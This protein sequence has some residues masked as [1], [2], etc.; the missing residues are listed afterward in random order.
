[1]RV[2][3]PCSFVVLETLGG[4]LI[5]RAVDGI[6][7]AL[8]PGDF[9]CLLVAIDDDAGAIQTGV[10]A[11]ERGDDA[12]AA[13]FDRPEIYEQHLI[14]AVMNQFAESVTA[15]RQ[16]RCRKFAFE[17]RILHAIP[18]AAHAL[19]DAA[20]AEVVGNVVADE[21]S[22]PH[23]CAGLS[24]RAVRNIMAKRRYT[25]PFLF[26]RIPEGYASSCSM[27]AKE[28]HRAVRHVKP[29]QITPRSGCA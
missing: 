18:E 13:A 7:P 19:V 29:I 27:K 10:R 15:A 9:A 4:A 3:V 20:K 6:D 16:I 24:A 12:L 23:G 11:S 5:A 14:L 17:Y 26:S 2:T 8:G 25:I 1:V 22:V 21:V 28:S